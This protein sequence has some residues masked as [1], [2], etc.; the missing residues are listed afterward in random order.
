M[1]VQESV[2]IFNPLK[3]GLQL[4]ALGTLAISPIAL[5]CSSKIV[6]K[7]FKFPQNQMPYFKYAKYMVLSTFLLTDG[8]KG[9]IAKQSLLNP[10]NKF[11]AQRSQFKLWF[12][13]TPRN[14]VLDVLSNLSIFRYYVSENDIFIQL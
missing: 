2:I 12:I 14:L 4:V 8:L 9:V 3:Y 10:F 1:Y 13:Q 5:F 11:Y 6:L 7:L